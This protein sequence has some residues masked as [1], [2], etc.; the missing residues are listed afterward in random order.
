[1][2]AAG[3]GRCC[4]TRIARTPPSD[5]SA[6]RRRADVV[7]V[8]RHVGLVARGSYPRDLDHARC[9]VDTDDVITATRECE[10]VRARS[11]AEVG[12]WSGRC[13]HVRELVGGP[14]DQLTM[15]R[16]AASPLA[17]PWLE[18]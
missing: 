16:L 8:E 1:M 3:C 14:L 5:A 13:N 11:A 7:H 6:K 2:K 9:T 4:T 15:L 10:R 18:E 17:L 12:H